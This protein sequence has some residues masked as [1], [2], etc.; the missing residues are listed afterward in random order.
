MSRWDAQ[1]RGVSKVTGDL[2]VGFKRLGE[3]IVAK[4]VWRRLEI[5]G[6][7]GLSRSSS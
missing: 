3:T 5:A 4:T 1:T 6:P 7:G 2:G